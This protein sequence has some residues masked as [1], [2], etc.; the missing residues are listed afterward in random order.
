MFSF[1]FLPCR[2][3]KSGKIY[4][5]SDNKNIINATNK[6]DGQEM[7]FYFNIGENEAQ[8]YVREKNEFYNKFVTLSKEELKREGLI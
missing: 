1:N 5:F 8:F 2:N 7:I 4:Y 3:K 6:N